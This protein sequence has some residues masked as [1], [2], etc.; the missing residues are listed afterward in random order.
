M[1]KEWNVIFMW[2]NFEM[3]QTLYTHFLTI[4]DDNE[5]SEGEDDWYNRTLVMWIAR[6]LL[7]LDHKDIY[8]AE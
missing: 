3:L 6:C 5:Y 7:F 2:A 1:L 4:F 8:L